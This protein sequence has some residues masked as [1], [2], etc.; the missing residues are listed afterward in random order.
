M[1]E[2]VLLLYMIM[3]FRKKKKKKNNNNKKKNVNI[4]IFIIKLQRFNFIHFNYL[5]KSYMRIGGRFGTGTFRPSRFGLGRFGQFLGW[6][7]SA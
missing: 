3:H 4:I 7:V 2:L 1:I 6:V 5:C